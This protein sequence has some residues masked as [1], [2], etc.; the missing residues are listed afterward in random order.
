MEQHVGNL[1]THVHEQSVKLKQC[2]TESEEHL[3]TERRYNDIV[4]ERLQIESLEASTLRSK[5]QADGQDV[6]R[7]M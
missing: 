5:L 1:S 7:T 2:E 6:P 4:Q 3:A